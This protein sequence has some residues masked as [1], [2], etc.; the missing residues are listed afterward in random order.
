MRIIL[1]VAACAIL[2]LVIMDQAILHSETLCKL[3]AIIMKKI[4][5]IFT[6]KYHDEQILS[7]L[8]KNNSYAK[9]LQSKI[10]LLTIDRDQWRHSSRNHSNDINNAYIDGYKKGFNDCESKKI[11][12]SSLKYKRRNI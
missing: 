6:T 11:K 9:D 5:G 4:I 12:Q 1:F 7:S 2:I 8:L 3:H 10:D